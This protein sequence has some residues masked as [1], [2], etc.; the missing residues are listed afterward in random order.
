[1]RPLTFQVLPLR[2]GFHARDALHF[3]VGKSGNT[4]RG[5]FGTIFRRLVCPEGCS[6]SDRCPKRASCPYV[7][8]FEPQASALGGSVRPSGLTDWPR[9]FVF[10]AAHLDGRTF[11]PGE[12]FHFDVH[13]F[14]CQ[15]PTLKY[16]ILAFSQLGREGLGPRRARADLIDIYRL[17]CRRQPVAQVFDGVTL[18][19]PE[20][21]SF[22][23]I[24]LKPEPEPVTRV[25]V[26]F[27]TPT[28][29]KSG[30]TLTL[31]PEFPILFAR[32]RDRI[33]AL[34]SLYGPG[35]L[36][37]D[38]KCMGEHAARVRMLGCNL[39]YAYTVRRSTRTQ[40]VHPLGGFVGEAEY[41]G[42]LTE[43]LPY[44]RAAFWTG[45]GR[46]TVWGKGVIRVVATDASRG[47]GAVE[48]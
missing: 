18:T 30:R 34:R 13:L 1:M 20:A 31:R 48:S 10:R 2:F 24:E 33:S 5:A 25:L 14:D 4:L 27:E 17:D 43:F 23:Q 12:S 35:P 19:E 16:F 37:I 36:L 29:L 47:R 7:R 45:V 39:E 38:F 3:P 40:Q 44:L 42:D 6:G 46:Q 28:E 15:G 21:S 26:R 41:E 11:A 8:V 9:P 32:I 22:V